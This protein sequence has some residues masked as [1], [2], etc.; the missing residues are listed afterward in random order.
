M[1]TLLN[2]VSGLSWGYFFTSGSDCLCCI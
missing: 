2:F 1:M